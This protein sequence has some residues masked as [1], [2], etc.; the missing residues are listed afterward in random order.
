VN[1]EHAITRR[2]R[3]VE[4]FGDGAGLPRWCCH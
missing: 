2:P 1:E 4:H 3:T